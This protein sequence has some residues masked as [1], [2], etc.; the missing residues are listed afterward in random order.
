MQAQ[1]FSEW[2][3]TERARRGITQRDLAD[4]SGVH[5][6][7]IAQ[8]EQGTREPS[9]EFVIKI[10]EAFGSTPTE[11]ANHLY[12]IGVRKTRV[13]LG[14]ASDDWYLAK[15]KRYARGASREAIEKAVAFFELGIKSFS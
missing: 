9:A 4:M 10:D 13:G 3:K 5:H 15:C 12:D 11:T 14:D 1:L 6:S 2:V 7:T 8:V